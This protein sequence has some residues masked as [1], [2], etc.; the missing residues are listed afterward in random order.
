MPRVFVAA[1]SNIE[2]EQNLALRH[3]RDAARRSPTSVSRPGT[4]TRPSGFEG[5]DFINFVAGFDT[6]LSVHDVVARLREIEELCG[7]PRGAPKWAPRSMDLDILLYGDLVC[8]EP[9]LKLPRPDL[10]QA[11]VHA[12][13]DGGSGAGGAAPDAERDHRR[14][15]AALRSGRA[16]DDTVDRLRARLRPGR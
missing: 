3:A 10:V 11:P 12:R 16:S 1:G 5:A 2:P 8:E 4:A 7:R 14:A 6:E 9:G 15:V 13:A